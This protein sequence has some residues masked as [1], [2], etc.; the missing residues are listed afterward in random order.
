MP[1]YL[2]LLIVLSL[3]GGSVDWLSIDPQRTLMATAGLLLGWAMLSH[4][5]A[6]MIAKQV[7]SKDVREVTGAIWVERQLEGM[8]WLGLGVIVICSAGF[9][10][11]QWIAQI[12]VVEHSMAA[13]SL[14]LLIPG[15]VIILSAW[16]AENLYGMVLGYTDLS[17]TDHV[18]TVLAAFRSGAAWLIV[19]VLLILLLTDLIRSL[20]ITENQATWATIVMMAITVPLG[21]PVL[22]RRLLHTEPLD[23]SFDW[24]QL[25]LQR[26]RLRGT[27]PIRWNT[28]NRSYNALVAGFVPGLRS[29]V[30]SDR[31]LDEMRPDQIGMIVLHEVAHLKRFHVPLRMFSVLPAWGAGM[32][33]SYL[34]QDWPWAGSVGSVS[35]IGLTLLVLRWVAY[36]TEFD[37]DRYAC[38]MAESLR[39]ELAE[40]PA[41]RSAAALSLAE[42]L[43]MVTRDQPGAQ[44]ATWLHPSVGQRSDRGHFMQTL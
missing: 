1:L 12:P 34:L 33:I 2:F 10:Y 22:V 19:P 26:C 36:L 35:A 38:R 31:I 28:G 42:A 17:L 11:G 3:S 15:V 24:I 27:P 18:K 44:K 5:G 25:I 40:L 21:I 9:G 20:P 43:A 30:V 32:A 23:Q 4:V 41:S 16:S 8:R 6:R 29:L 14:L 7:L 39:G 13:Q 37:A